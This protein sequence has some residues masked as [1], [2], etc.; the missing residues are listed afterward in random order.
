MVQYDATNGPISLLALSESAVPCTENNVSRPLGSF[1]SCVHHHR[2]A[3]PD[4]QN[5][6]VLLTYQL[7][8]ALS[9]Y[10]FPTRS[11]IPRIVTL[12]TLR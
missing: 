6:P 9:L 12:M 5:E 3:S 7:I 10:F 1:Q 4:G 8:S 2:L 11:H